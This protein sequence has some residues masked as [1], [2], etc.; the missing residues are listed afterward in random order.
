M[1]WGVPVQAVDQEHP[2][3]AI[4][5]GVRLDGRVVGHR[6]GNRVLAPAGDRVDQPDDGSQSLAEHGRHV[7]MVAQIP[8]P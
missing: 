8:R 5:R 1:D 6:R 3:R 2:V 7:R 4:A